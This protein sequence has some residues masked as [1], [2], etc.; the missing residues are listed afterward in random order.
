MNPAHVTG[1]VPPVVTPLRSDRSLD[2]DALGRQLERLVAAGVDGIFVL[3]STGEAAFCT[4]KERRAVIEESVRVVDGRVPVLAGVVDMQ[5][6]RVVEHIRAAEEAGADAVVATA[7]FYAITPADAVRRHFELLSVAA[8]VPVYAYDIPV[9]VHAKL[10]PEMLVALGGD[11]HLAGVK[12]SSGDDV[13]FRRL[14]LLN[15]SAGSPL[16]LLTGHEVVVDGA[17]LSGA[18][19]VVPG[20]GNVD[21]DAYVR[22]HRAAQAGD[23]AAVRAE[24]DR[25]AQL[26]DIVRVSRVMSGWGAGVGGFKTALML[27]GVLE[28]N[29]VPEPFTPLPAEDVDR[30]KAIL[31]TAGL[32]G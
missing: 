5:T 26:M 16:T 28:T 18:D 1:V 15:R 2:R 22:M 14:S 20:L 24:Q 11:G 10:D 19:G 32:L 4:D 30:V 31:D 21:P 8:Q 3:G 13:G 6:S 23:W 25:L 7:P 12:D 29:Q 9:C 27:L 17:Y